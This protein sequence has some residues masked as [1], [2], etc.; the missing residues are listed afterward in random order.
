MGGALPDWEIQTHA[1]ETQTAKMKKQ[2][3]LPDHATMNGLYTYISMQCLGP[4]Q[5]GKLQRRAEKRLYRQHPLHPRTDSHTHSVDGC[6]QW[7]HNHLSI[8]ELALHQRMYVGGAKA[9]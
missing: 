7:L 9:I 3:S 2:L 5:D 4:G 1:P 6:R 8:A